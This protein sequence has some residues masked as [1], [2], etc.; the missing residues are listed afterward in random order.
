MAPAN[1]FPDSFSFA[2]SAAVISISTPLM[3]RAGFIAGITFGMRFVSGNLVISLATILQRRL[4]MTAEISY[5]RG[6]PRRNLPKV[7]RG[8]CVTGAITVFGF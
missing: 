2:E 4:T 8:S 6:D 3:S 7:Q 1:A 5:R